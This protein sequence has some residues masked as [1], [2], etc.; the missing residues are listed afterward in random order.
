MLT[1][2]LRKQADNVLAQAAE[3]PAA[4]VVVLLKVLMSVLF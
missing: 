1:R 2:T 4:K 3:V